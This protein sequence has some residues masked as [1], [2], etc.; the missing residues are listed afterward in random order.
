M[1]I[2]DSE[3]LQQFNGMYAGD[4]GD[5]RMYSAKVVRPTKGKKCPGNFAEAL[6]DVAAKTRGVVERALIDGK[7]RSCYTCEDC[8]ITWAKK[9]R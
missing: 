7:W 4:D 5:V 2:S 9:E 8:I 6:H 3:L 1:A